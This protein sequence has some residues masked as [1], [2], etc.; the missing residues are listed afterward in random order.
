MC[1]PSR[2]DERRSV[3]Q[4]P[5]KVIEK[6]VS[7]RVR[8]PQVAGL[9]R[10]A[11][12][13]NVDTPRS[14]K[15]AAHHVAVITGTRPRRVLRHGCLGIWA[16]ARHRDTRPLLLEADAA[17]A[18]VSVAG[19]A[20]SLA[21]K[22]AAFAALWLLACD[23]SSAIKVALAAPLEKPKPTTLEA[24]IRERPDRASRREQRRTSSVRKRRDSQ[25]LRADAMSTPS[26]S[27]GSAAPS[28]D[29]K[30]TAAELAAEKGLAKQATIPVA[31]GA[32]CFEGAG[33][34]GR[35]EIHRLCSSRD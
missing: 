33:Y 9:L 13:A 29:R 3:V 34:T 15:V 19:G 8:S 22:E 16:L 31:I 2:E 35:A 18:L 1:R 30:P 25:C 17:V 20:A 27:F 23:R 5:Q 7:S 11:L 4:S 12:Y 21:T 10:L 26:G 6:T 32:A 28:L 24:A 14:R